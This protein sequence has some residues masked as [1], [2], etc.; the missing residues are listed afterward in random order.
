L[1]EQLKGLGLTD[2]QLAEVDGSD[3]EWVM[4]DYAFAVLGP[5]ARGDDAQKKVYSK[6]FDTTPGPTPADCEKLLNEFNIEDVN[7]R[8]LLKDYQYYYDTGKQRRPQVWRDRGKN[9]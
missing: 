2:E 7:V 3:R 8:E 6:T 4:L 9:R 1:L 5:L